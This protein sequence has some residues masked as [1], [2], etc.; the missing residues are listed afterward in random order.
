MM[1]HD[2]TSNASTCATFSTCITVFPEKPYRPLN[3]NIQARTFGN[4]P[5]ERSFKRQC[6]QKYIWSHYDIKLNKAFRH[7]CMKEKIL[8]EFSATNSEEAF[9]KTG[10]QNWKH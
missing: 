5:E 3:V 1:Q 8:R 2:A 9:T 10:F 6:Y 7:S 4:D